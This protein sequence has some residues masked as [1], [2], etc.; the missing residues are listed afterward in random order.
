MESVAYNGTSK[1]DINMPLNARHPVAWPVI[2]RA[3]Y[4]TFE[5]GGWSSTNSGQKLTAKLFFNSNQR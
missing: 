3:L 1:D 2:A 5:R 4:P